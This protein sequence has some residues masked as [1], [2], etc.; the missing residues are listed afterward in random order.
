MEKV[1]TSDF[2][3]PAAKLGVKPGWIMEEVNGQPVR[4]LRLTEIKSILAKSKLP[5]KV[6]FLA[7]KKIEYNKKANKNK[8]WSR[9]GK[10]KG[11]SV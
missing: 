11:K 10:G 2:S 4:D 3:K 9:G 8:D 1:N 7:E 5:V 6:A